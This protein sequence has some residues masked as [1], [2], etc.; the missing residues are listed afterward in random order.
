MRPN[1][2]SHISNLLA[3]WGIPSEIW[4]KV[5]LDTQLEIPDY[6]ITLTFYDVPA[7]VWIEMNDLIS[8]EKVM[9]CVPRLFR[10]SSL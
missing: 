2:D 3:E 10:G 5:D 8:S 9:Q 1:F 4:V 7:V 6:D